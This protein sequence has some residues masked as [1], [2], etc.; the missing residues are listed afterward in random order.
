MLLVRAAP[1]PESAVPAGKLL[2]ERAQNHPR[3]N[4]TPPPWHR[5]AAPQLTSESSIPT[6]TEAASKSDNL[7][8]DRG[9][10]GANGTPPPWHRDVA[11][12][13]PT[14]GTPTPTAA[15]DAPGWR[16]RA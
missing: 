1:L 16:R 15:N 3:Q 8:A 2:A 14:M 13:Q 9:H 5:E 12:I 6:G 10:T 4:G 7:L 11:A